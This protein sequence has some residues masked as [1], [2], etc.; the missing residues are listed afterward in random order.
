M[1]LDGVVGHIEIL[2]K[3]V[4]DRTI[5]QAREVEIDLRFDDLTLVQVHL[6]VPLSPGDT[7]EEE[8]LLQD[9]LDVGLE[10]VT[11]P[12]VVDPS[13]LRQD[14]WGGSR[15][16]LRSEVIREGRHFVDVPALFGDLDRD[17]GIRSFQTRGDLEAVAEFDQ[18]GVAPERRIRPFRR[19]GLQRRPGPR[20]GRHQILDG[21]GGLNRS[22][23]MLVM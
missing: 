20:D 22:G 6:I 1:G 16:D 21:G 18:R 19:C 17:T 2:F 11:R 3:L 14:A 15:T 7:V 12:E 10:C 4:R 5:V 8:H 13:A 9:S 23:R